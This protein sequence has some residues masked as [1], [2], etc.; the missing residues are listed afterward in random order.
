MKIEVM[1]RDFI[2]ATIAYR[3]VSEELRE[4]ASGQ[5]SEKVKLLTNV[6]NELEAIIETCMKKVDMRKDIF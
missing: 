1:R 3:F 5:N 6:Q 4:V 2:L